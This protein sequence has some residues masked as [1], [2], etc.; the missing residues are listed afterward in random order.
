MQVI[1]AIVQRRV[2]RHIDTTGKSRAAHQLNDLSRMCCA[3]AARNNMEG[4]QQWQ[5]GID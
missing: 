2:L 3:S 5:A 4:L 1:W